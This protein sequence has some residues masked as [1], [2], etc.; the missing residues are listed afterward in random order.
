MRFSSDEFLPFNSRRED[1]T[2]EL[3]ATYK[4]PELGYMPTLS[5]KGY[6]EIKYTGLSS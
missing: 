6:W 5:F 4:G 3:L 2:P 1:L